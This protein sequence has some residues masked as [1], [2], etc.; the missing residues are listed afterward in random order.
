MVW[1]TA[2]M[3]SGLS[4][5]LMLNVNFGINNDSISGTVELL[6]EALVSL[7]GVDC[8][9]SACGGTTCWRASL[10]ESPKSIVE[11]EAPRM[12]T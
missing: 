6:T 3:S 8:D 1:K 12:E 11:V 7:A 5:R 2:S 4:S 10:L 9:G